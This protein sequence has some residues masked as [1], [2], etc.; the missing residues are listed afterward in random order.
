MPSDHRCVLCNNGRNRDRWIIMPHVLD[1]QFHSPKIEEFTKWEKKIDIK[2][3]KVT[4]HTKICSNH[5]KFAKPLENSAVPS[6]YLRGYPSWAV[7]RKCAA[8]EVAAVEDGLISNI[9]VHISKYLDPVTIANL[10]KQFGVQG[11]QLNQTLLQL[12]WPTARYLVSKLAP[13]V[14]GGKCLEALFIYRYGGLLDLPANEQL[15]TTST[16]INKQPTISSRTEDTGDC[17]PYSIGDF[18][19]Y[20]KTGV[21]LVPTVHYGCKGHDKDCTHKVYKNCQ[22]NKKGKKMLCGNAN[23]KE[24]TVQLKKHI[25]K[26]ENLQENLAAEALRSKQLTK[27]NKSLEKKSQ[28]MKRLVDGPKVSI[29][30]IKDSDELIHLHTGLASYKVFEWVFKEVEPAAKTMA[31]WHGSD[32][33]TPKKFLQANQN[34]PGPARLLS[35]PNELLLTLM[36][37]RHNMT[38]DYL[39]FLFNISQPSVL[40]ILST[41]IPFLGH[42]LCGLIY[43]PEKEEV[44]LCYPRCFKPWKGIRA[45][46]DCFE[47]ATQKPSHVEANTQVFSAYKN[48][49]TTKFL[50]ACTPGGSVSFLSPPAGGNM[51]DKELVLKSEF[52]D[53]FS[54]GDKCMVDEGFKIKGELL[55]HGVELIIPPFLNKGQPFT[56]EKNVLNKEVTHAGIHVERVIGRVREYRFL[57]GPVPVNQLDLIGP[58]A[59]VC[60]ALTNLK[61]S[62]IKG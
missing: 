26:I 39:A 21:P 52:L 47:V 25:Q 19:N 2:N 42:E 54:P 44:P 50:L 13:I 61:P 10:G 60:C 16:I 36:K 3:F 17:T 1:L 46:L 32:S 8:K 6:Q 12:P 34:R 51:S 23:C 56:E 40:S 33:A 7:S 5:F 30:C 62:V 20:T 35:Q 41:W 48:R 58:A 59:T 28:E 18:H 38:E 4:K 22:R 24:L 27:E 15:Q 49:P 11:E 14:P 57:A 55:E 9:L 45:I 31:Y 29:E 53:K 43:W 37:L